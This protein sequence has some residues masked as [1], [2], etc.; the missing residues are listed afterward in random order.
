MMI[1]VDPRNLYLLTMTTIPWLIDRAC[2]NS[3]E[4]LQSQILKFL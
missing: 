4:Q 2:N 3:E 1:T